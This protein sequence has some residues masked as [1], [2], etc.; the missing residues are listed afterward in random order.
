MLH[1]TK[2]IGHA[3]L[4]ARLRNSEQLTNDWL[5][6]EWIGIRGKPSNRSSVFVG[7][8]FLVIPRNVEA[9]RCLS[10]CDNKGFNTAGPIHNAL[11]E[12]WERVDWQADLM[13]EVCTLAV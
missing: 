9:L 12:H 2:L 6:I 10:F 3:R 1:L 4:M 5:S 8:E 11:V 7:D 13:E